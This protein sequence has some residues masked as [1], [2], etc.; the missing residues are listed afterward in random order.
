MQK[1]S[2]RILIDGREF[3]Q[4]KRTGIGRFL[5]SFIDAL[6]NSE[7]DIEVV[8]ASFKNNSISPK[9]KNNPA[10][11]VKKISESFFPSEK[12]LSDQSKL[13]V[14]LFISPYPKIPFLGVHC[15]AVHTVHDVFDLTHH[16]YG[17]RFKVYFDRFRLRSAL[18]KAALTWYVSEWSKKETLKY[19]EIVGKNPRV[20][21]NGIDARF[22]DEVSIG[23]T[24]AALEKYGLIQGFVLVVGNGLPHKNLGVLL[25]IT[26][27]LSRPVVF[28]GVPAE[29]VK[30]WK[31]RYPSSDATW[32]EHIADKDFLAVMK[33]AFCLAQPSTDEG[34]GYPPLEAMAAGIPVVVSD[35]P[36]LI[37]TT[38]GNGITAKPDN[39]GA[40]KEAFDNLAIQDIYEK[41]VE[42][43]LHWVAPL[44]GRK[45]WQKHVADIKEMLAP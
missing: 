38:G 5:E 1:P 39:S 45:G 37:E 24:K 26:N 44:L 14:D 41:Q 2:K 20:R 33:G 35:I 36:V 31:A 28:L 4:D 8:I 9:I 3:V 15:P 40:W 11:V 21:Y 23:E 32:V 29:R 18:K 10:V 42:E 17:R 6:I 30:Y 27:S 13:G 19:A 7:L 12:A 34:Y 43:G 25:E 22:S 16:E